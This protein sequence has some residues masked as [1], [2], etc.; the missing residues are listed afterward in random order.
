MTPEEIE[1]LR[2]LGVRFGEYARER[3]AFFY[4]FSREDNYARWRRHLL[5]AADDC[6][7][8]YN[9]TLISY[10]EFVSIFTSPSGEIND[11]K[12]PRD[13]ITLLMIES[14]A[15]TDDPLFEEEDEAETEEA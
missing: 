13:L 9:Y 15:G 3:R 8:R 1:T 7:R 11:W 6:V 10:D 2:E 14:R 12:L 4:D 5:R